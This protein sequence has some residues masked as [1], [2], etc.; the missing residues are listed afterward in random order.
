MD[1]KMTIQQRELIQRIAMITGY[2]ETVVR[3]I[4][5]A[6][7]EFVLD[8]IKCGTP[9][10]IGNIGILSVKEREM[11]NG[12]DFTNRQVRDGMKIAKIIKFNA[13]AALK[14]AVKGKNQ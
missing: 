7:T 2:S 13:S 5:K 6:E 3:D 11:R 10:K 1:R 9:V 8:E 4:V 14:R 12:Y